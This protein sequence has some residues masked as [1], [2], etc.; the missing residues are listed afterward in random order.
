M[1]NVGMK[2]LENISK[3]RNTVMGNK[4]INENNVTE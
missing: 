4:G 3:I 2:Y 1:L